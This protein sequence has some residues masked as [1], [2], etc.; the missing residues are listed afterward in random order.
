MQFDQLRAVWHHQLE[1]PVSRNEVELIARLV[2]QCARDMERTLL[3]RDLTESTVA[4]AGIIS[5]GWLAVRLPT[6]IGK[7]GCLVIVAGAVLIIAKLWH[8]PPWRT[9]AGGRVASRWLPIG[10]TAAL[11]PANP[12]PPERRMVVHQPDLYRRESLHVGEFSIPGL[13]GLFPRS[14]SYLKCVHMAVEPAGYSNRVATDAR[15]D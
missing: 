9:T 12:P 11:D 13:L 8:A 5:F 3:R 15:R 1:Q 6:V 2:E 7:I 10:R 14:S 4:V